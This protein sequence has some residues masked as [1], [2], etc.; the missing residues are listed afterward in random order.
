MIITNNYRIK[1]AA[2]NITQSEL[3]RE[4]K[5]RNML[6][7]YNITASELSAALSGT[8]DS[9]KAK[10]MRQAVDLL[11]AERANEDGDSKSD[12]R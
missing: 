10:A 7:E 6:P 4:I 8:L 11:I 12:Y 5:G 3:I 2:A 9:P 1:L